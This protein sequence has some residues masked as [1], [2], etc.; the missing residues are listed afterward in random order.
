MKLNFEKPKK[1]VKN[2]FLGT[3]ATVSTLG[4]SAE[5]NQANPSEGQ[6]GIKSEVVSQDVRK[7]QESVVNMQQEML[8]LEAKK[9]ETQKHKL[10]E[11]LD[12]LTKELHQTQSS[13][14]KS[15]M[16][17]FDYLG[18][19][20]KYKIDGMEYKIVELATKK[21]QEKVDQYDI[22]QEQFVNDLLG[23]LLSQNGEL[24]NFIEQLNQFSG[25][26]LGSPIMLNTDKPGKYESEDMVIHRHLGTDPKNLVKKAL[27]IVKCRY[28]IEKAR[29]RLAGI[30]EEPNDFAQK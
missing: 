29:Q 26:Q 4:A 25:Q 23:I 11:Q 27:E 1:W 20:D 10:E 5:K 18:L 19:K 12:K 15:Y 7:E 28:D 9:I 6:L 14:S 16:Q 17:A 8:L 22:T 30:Y 24:G 3:V 13:F 2:T 21:G